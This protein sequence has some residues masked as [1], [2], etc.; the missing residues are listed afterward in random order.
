MYNVK[1]EMYN[2]VIKIL[3]DDLKENLEVFQVRFKQ[4]HVY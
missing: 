2:I 1:E 4:V 3:I